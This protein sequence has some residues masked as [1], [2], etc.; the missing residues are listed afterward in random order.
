MKTPSYVLGALLVLAATEQLTP[1]MA[2]SWYPIECCNV[3][4]CAPVETI[5][6][7]DAYGARHL[8]VTS[9]HGTVIIPP[10][11]PLRASPDGRMHVCMRRSFDDGM[12]VMCLFNPPGA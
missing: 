2:H 6:W 10:N 12:E 9:R 7:V 5:E 4:D 11:F 8:Y 3:R 1:A